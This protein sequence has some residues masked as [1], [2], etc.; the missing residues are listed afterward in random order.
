ML[1]KMRIQLFYSSSIVTLR[2]NEVS[3]REYVET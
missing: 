1:R 3:L 2:F